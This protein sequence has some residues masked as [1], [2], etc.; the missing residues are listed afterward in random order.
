MIKYQANIPKELVDYIFV[1]AGNKCHTCLVS[2]EF[3]YKK[4]NNFYFCCNRC[5]MHI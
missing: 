4:I 3:P 1:L 5:Y 2:C